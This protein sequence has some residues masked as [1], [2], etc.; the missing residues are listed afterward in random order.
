VA[1]DEALLKSCAQLLARAERPVIFIGDGV[2]HSGA[3]DELTRVA[4]L[5]GPTRAS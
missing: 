4:E 2:A 5:L 1:P 3:Q